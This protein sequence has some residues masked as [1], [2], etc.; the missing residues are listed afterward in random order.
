[1]VSGG[2]RKWFELCGVVPLGVYLVVHVGAYAR[3]LLGATSFGLGR[4]SA[5]SLALE[6]GLVWLP[7]GFHSVYG[8]KLSV[9]PLTG[10]PEERKAS[11]LLRVSGVLALAFLIQHAVWLRWPLSSGAL[12]P[13]DMGDLLKGTL[14]STWNGMP[15]VA[16]LHLLGLG[17]VTAH[18]GWGLGRFLE[19]WGVAQRS[20]ARAIS[21]WFAAMIFCVGTATII[22]LATGS[23]VPR[24][25]R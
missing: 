8:L 21:G 12:W 10:D 14:S 13:S 3:A 11:V 4:S 22:E 15:A 25:L 19:R 18:F 7:L 1:M 9:S 23:V 5:A 17:A 20:R 2:I 6:V 24:F 16:A